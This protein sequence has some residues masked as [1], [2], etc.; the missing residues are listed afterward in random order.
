[1]ISLAPMEGI[2]TYV[3]R[4]ALNRH[5]GG[6]DKYYTP[7]LTASNIKGREK[8][9]VDP[10]NN[11]VNI[12]IPQVLVND[13][14]LFLTIA[15]QLQALGYNEVNLNLGC[16]SGT[17]TA[18]GRGAGFLDKTDELDRFLE[19]IFDKSP[20]EISIKTRIGMEFISEWEDIAEI[21]V[22]YPAKEIIIH[23]RVGKELYKGHAHTDI[24]ADMVKRLAPKMPNTI[25]TY[26]GDITSP[27]VLDNIRKTISST[28]MTDNISKI[29]S[30]TELTDNISKTISSTEGFN[31]SD[32]SDKYIRLSNIMI[33]RGVIA[34]PDLC[35]EIR[36]GQKIDSFKKRFLAFH[37]ELIENYLIEMNYED[38]VVKKMK[39]LWVYFAKGLDLPS[40]V[41]KELLK[42]TSLSSYKNCFSVIKGYI[43]D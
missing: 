18:K 43:K 38:Q 42:A 3:Y 22:K 19:Q 37:E 30:S 36:N 33:G 39:E 13:A 41:I 24:Y 25:F 35:Y 7:F 23:P 14:E 1:M 10:A 26:N 28:E 15:K 2:T 21:Y 12:L 29:I 34:N 31:G 4:N 16:P 40:K 6:I 9:D 32:A 20:I 17:V 11:D 5:F 27:E 8:R